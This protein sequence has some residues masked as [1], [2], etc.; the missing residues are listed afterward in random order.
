MAVFEQAEGDDSPALVTV[1]ARV[2]G[3]FAFTVMIVAPLLIGALLGY[4]VTDTID[5]PEAMAI[6]ANLPLV[7]S[8]AMDKTSRNTGGS[9]PT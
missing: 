7:S 6:K 8:E 9:F 3:S 4:L 5:D 1:L 2:L